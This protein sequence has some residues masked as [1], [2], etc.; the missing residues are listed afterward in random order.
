M[1]IV[2][3]HK[4]SLATIPQSLPFPSLVMRLEG[5]KHVPKPGQIKFETSNHNL[6]VF[7][8]LYPLAQVTDNRGVANELYAA[9][10]GLELTASNMAF[11]HGG[12]DFLPAPKVEIEPRWIH[13]PFNFQ[14][15]NYDR[16][17]LKRLFALFSEPG[18]GKT[19]TA[20][21][22]MCYRFM[23]RLLTGTAVVA[24]PSGVSPQWVHEQIPEHI[25]PDIHILAAHWDGKRWPDWV[26]EKTPGKLQFIA[27]NVEALNFDRGK[28]GLEKFLEVHAD[29]GWL[30]IDESQTLMTP[31]SKRTK[32]AI[33]LGELVS[34]RSIMTGTPIAK[35]LIDE[36]SQF[37]FLDEDII[38]HKYQATFKAQFCV[39]GGDNGRQVVGSRNIDQFNGLVAP[40]IF[41]AT[42]KDELDLPAKS[43]DEVVFDLTPKQKKHQEELKKKFITMLD[44]GEV[45][46]V[47]NAATLIIRLQQLACGYL[48]ADDGSI[49]DFEFNPRI[50]ALNTHLSRLDQK[51][52]IW[53]RFNRDIELIKAQLGSRAVTYYG[54]NTLGERKDAKEAF[55]S[56]TSGVDRIIA[57]Q[58]AMGAGV[59]GLQRV[60]SRAIYYSNSFNSISRWQSEDRIDRVGMIG[61]A[62]YDD[63]IARGSVDRKIVNNLKAKKSFSDM[64]L[65]DVR[66]MIDEL[67]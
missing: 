61:G 2:I 59:D 49:E 43:Y 24:W 67:N 50:D 4:T 65:G 9:M 14:R 25:W 13:E 41:R 63:F 54:P 16:F 18:T 32:E 51:V 20:V 33:R 10:G 58:E 48:V 15:K 56:P 52:I 35:N 22:I 62:M 42:K 27:M 17:K 12:D 26:G 46:S 57:N 45:T 31:G 28:A 53:A 34:Q 29:K 36:W 66:R 19:K 37:N 21:D 23:A 1:N 30:Q 3:D 39:M 44:S 40:H 11:V 7:A 5:R 55:C 60:C 64:V 38:G 6:K 8:E 47:K